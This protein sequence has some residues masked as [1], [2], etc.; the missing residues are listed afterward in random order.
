MQNNNKI[1]DLTHILAAQTPTMMSM[2]VLNKL[3]VLYFSF[4][5]SY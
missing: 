5:K 1:S 2:D 4:S 3:L